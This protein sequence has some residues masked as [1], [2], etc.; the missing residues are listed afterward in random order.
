MSLLSF[1][2]FSHYPFEKDGRFLGCDVGEKTIGLALSDRNRT[3]SSPFTVIRRTQWKKDSIIFFQEV[4]NHHICGIVVGFPLNMNGSEG[5]RCQS[6]RQFVSNLLQVR[7]LPV[8]LWDERLST[9]A[10]TR[11]LLEADLSR[12]KRTQVVDKMAACY[13][14][15]GFLDALGTKI[16]K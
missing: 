7:D 6:T 15:Q 1:D 13:I 3:I 5:P 16:A 10:V 4:D 14:L 11:T 12:A 9:I 2:D 8:C